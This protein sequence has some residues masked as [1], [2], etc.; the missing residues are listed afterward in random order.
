MLALDHH[1]FE[2][3]EDCVRSDLGDHELRAVDAPEVG[4]IVDYRRLDE[5]LCDLG[6]AHG[7]VSLLHILRLADVA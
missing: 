1:E 4:I 2:E 6:F 7:V 5:W 3:A